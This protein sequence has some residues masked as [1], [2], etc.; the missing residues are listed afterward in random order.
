MRRCKRSRKECSSSLSCERPSFCHPLLLLPLLLTRCFLLGD[1]CSSRT[2]ARACV[3][4]RAL[5]PDRQTAP[6]SQTAISADIHQTFDVH[7]NPLA[8]IAFN[9]VLCLQY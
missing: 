1:G 8:Q 9:F 5:A 4:V 2:L 3:G 6:V 7:L